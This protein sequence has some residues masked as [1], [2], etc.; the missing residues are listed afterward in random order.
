[1]ANQSEG[2]MKAEGQDFSPAAA[3]SKSRPSSGNL[4]VPNG[5]QSTGAKDDGPHHEVPVIRN[6]ASGHHLAVSYE[7]TH[8]LQLCPSVSR[9]RAEHN[10]G[11]HSRELRCLPDGVQTVYA[12][13][14]SSSHSNWSL[15]DDEVR[16][17]ALNG[18]ACVRPKERCEKTVKAKKSKRRWWKEEK[19]DLGSS[20]AQKLSLADS[21]GNECIRST[22]SK[23]EC[24]CNDDSD[25]TDIIR[26]NV[27]TSPAP[28]RCQQ[29]P[30]GGLAH[31]SEQVLLHKTAAS[32]RISPCYHCDHRSDHDSPAIP[33][34]EDGS[35]LLDLVDEGAV[36]D[37]D[38]NVP[39][40][41]NSFFPF[42]EDT[43]I[44]PNSSET[45][46]DSYYQNGHV[47]NRNTNDRGQ[48]H[49]L[50]R[51]EQYFPVHHQYGSS[52][53]A[54]SDG[55]H[56]S[57]LNVV[58]GVV[59]RWAERR[60]QLDT[61]EDNG[62]FIDADLPAISSRLLSSSAGSA[63]LSS[64]NGDAL[65]SQGA[66]SGFSVGEMSSRHEN[67][68]S[69]GSDKELNHQNDS[70][71]VFAMGSTT[72]FPSTSQDT[73]FDA[74]TDNVLT[75]KTE[76]SDGVF[77]NS[78][79]SENE[80][81]L[82]D[83][84]VVQGHNRGQAALEG[85]GVAEA[86]MCP[87]SRQL[88]LEQL[89][90]G[91]EGV[92]LFFDRHCCLQGNAWHPGHVASSLPPSCLAG[93]SAARHGSC[94]NLHELPE[95]VE[96]GGACAPPVNNLSRLHPCSTGSRGMEPVANGF[97]DVAPSNFINDQ[98]NQQQKVFVKFPIVQEGHDLECGS[99]AGQ[100]EIKCEND[101]ILY[102][103][104]I[105]PVLSH[106]HNTGEKGDELDPAVGQ[107]CLGP[108]LESF[109]MFLHDHDSTK[110]EP[111]QANS[112]SG[113]SEPIYEE[114]CEYP[115]HGRDCSV[116]CIHN[117]FKF[118]MVKKGGKDK[119]I[120]CRPIENG[121]DVTTVDRIMIWNEYEAYLLQV[122]QIGMSA[123]G[124]TAV[125][126]LLK[127]FDLPAE[128]DDVCREIH[129]NL[130]KEKASIAEYLASRA[131]A[132]TT[133][134]DLLSGVER[135]TKGEVR[136]RFFHFWPPRHVQLLSW[137]S[138][139]MKKGAVPI[140]T[141]N[142]QLGVTWQQ[143]PDAW[144][145]QMVYGVGSRGVYLTNPLEIVCEDTLMEQLT[146]DSVLLVR[147]QD[148]V[149]RF[150]PSVSLAPLIAHADPR[151]CTMNVLGQVV[152]VLREHNMP[153]VPGYRAQL[154]SHIRIPA[155]YRAGITLYVRHNSSAWKALRDACDLPLKT[156][157]QDAEH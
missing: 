66:C 57:V 75:P 7:T 70:P 132:G 145:H 152:N 14:I 22:P 58:E 151:W 30:C 35:D 154:T 32:S 79:E 82:S 48:L 147:R 80:E 100:V 93:Q 97:D 43:S 74:I 42:L 65:E 111:W 87:H 36:C 117:T 107:V 123:C 105:P 121:S 148:V 78:S 61:S 131:V 13:G 133:A 129:V 39:V 31:S 120:V 95:E 119:K 46:N 23:A 124:Q 47:L 2:G 109:E 110:E 5:Q 12:N 149:S 54:E 3:A 72:T 114:I 27:L 11:F 60:Q 86:Q 134:E 18:E 144:H 91:A 62:D 143:I 92:D 98:S 34:R 68:L 76:S 139:W 45:N 25:K 96:A 29:T 115:C 9:H 106:R 127:A 118:S 116:P 142:L 94:P 102:P 125:L 17:S 141:L 156:T 67:N 73:D 44:P 138:H 108:N 146:S 140:A 112:E 4:P 89:S 69:G 15:D 77:G 103:C 155:V 84:P 33:R 51:A 40:E 81:E 6:G 55:D 126:N 101:N 99:G 49:Q 59:G 88:V 24:T 8:Q 16:Q 37:F 71:V 1:M 85:A 130:R 56:E 150:Q 10:H 137:L 38:K 26:S 50:R 153:S 52:S 53:D 64:S 83:I 90:L 136:G 113:V 20:V 28:C 128:K 63:S 122:K 104:P 41:E 21:G 19:Q 135:L 157:S